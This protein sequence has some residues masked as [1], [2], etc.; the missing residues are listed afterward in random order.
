MGRPLQDEVEA[1][2]TAAFLD[3]RVALGESTIRICFAMALRSLSL[4]AEKR[5]THPR[6]PVS[7]TRTHSVRRVPA[8]GLFCLTLPLLP[9]DNNQTLA[10]RV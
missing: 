6:S 8:A 4:R 1:D 3:H 9:G 5:S 7:P 2:S 10:G